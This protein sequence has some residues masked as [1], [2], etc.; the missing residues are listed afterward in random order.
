MAATCKNGTTAPRSLL[1]NGVGTHRL[2]TLRLNWLPVFEKPVNELLSLISTL[3]RLQ[4]LD[5]DLDNDLEPSTWFIHLKALLQE[6]KSLK[7]LRLAGPRSDLKLTNELLSSLSTCR[8][9]IL[10]LET[11]IIWANDISAILSKNCETIRKIVFSNVCIQSGYWDRVLSMVS[12]LP[13]C[14]ELCM[15]H[16]TYYDPEHDSLY[17]PTLLNHLRVFMDET[18][19]DLALELLSSR[20]EDF[21]AL[22]DLLRAVSTRT[23]RSQHASLVYIYTEP[24][25]KPC[26]ET[27]VCLA[28]CPLAE[29]QANPSKPGKVLSSGY[30]E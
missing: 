4:T 27:S 13:R 26:L 12:T 14:T 21:H 7:S 22:G 1:E 25:G 23:E 29:A 6:L 8:L 18:Q 28:L 24:D 17:D 30:Q 3:N 16:L 10:K 15:S 5:L 2:R 11:T 19:H 20:W 9:E